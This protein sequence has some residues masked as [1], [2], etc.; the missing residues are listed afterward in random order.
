[1]GTVCVNVENVDDEN[2]QVEMEMDLLE[3]Y[4]VDY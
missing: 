1:M 2:D 3:D 4:K